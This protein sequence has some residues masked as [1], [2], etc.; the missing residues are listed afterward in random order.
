[1][2]RFSLVAAATAVSERARQERV[3]SIPTLDEAVEQAI[4]AAMLA[5]QD[6]FVAELCN[7]LDV[8][9]R[10]VDYFGDSLTTIQ[11]G[12]V[13]VS[14]QVMSDPH[15]IDRGTYVV[16]KRDDKVLG[17][18]TVDGHDQP[19]DAVAKIVKLVRG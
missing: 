10:D 16:V 13:L 6:G 11:V 14:V 15:K 1:M 12:D 2:R 5:W 8:P 9:P 7:S 17:H 4:K 3:A 19:A 18:L